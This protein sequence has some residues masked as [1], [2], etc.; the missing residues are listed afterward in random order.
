MFVNHN[1]CPCLRIAA[2]TL[3]NNGCK[4]RA[5]AHYFDLMSFTALRNYGC[6]KGV[7]HSLCHKTGRAAM[8]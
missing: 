6:R 5:K 4:E 8:V 2:G 1:L 7:E 3:I